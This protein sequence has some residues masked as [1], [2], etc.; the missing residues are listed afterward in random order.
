MDRVEP[1]RKYDRLLELLKEAGSALVA[2][3]GGVDS[4][5][6]LH[7]ARSALGDRVAAATIDTP[8]IPRW[9]IREAREFIAP[10]GVRHIVVEMDFPDELR[11]NPADHCYTCKKRLFGTLLDV[12]D[13]NG[14]AHVLDGTNVDDLGDYRPGLKALRELNILSPLMEAGLTKQDIR[15][16]SRR[17]GLPT[18]DKPS[19]ACL[20]SRMPIDTK[21]ND[22]DLRRVEL[23]EVFLMSLGFRGVRVRSHGGVARIEVPKDR[24]QD[25]VQANENNKIDRYLKELGFRHVALDLTGYTMGSLNPASEET[26]G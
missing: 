23:S 13:A 6:L 8:Y 18:W 19:F 14:L 5:F 20:L 3:S 26:K 12:A 15:D 1:D 22:A 10:L 24:I 16:L 2:Y 4:T 11:T 9:E 21:V 25:L 17:F 7:A